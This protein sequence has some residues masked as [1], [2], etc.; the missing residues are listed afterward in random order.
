MKCNLLIVI[1]VVSALLRGHAALYAAEPPQPPAVSPGASG[2]VVAVADAPKTE[3]KASNQNDP[4]I[5]SAKKVVEQY[6]EAILKKD[7]EQ[8]LKLVQT[9]N[10]KILLKNADTAAAQ[11]RVYKVGRGEIENNENEAL[12]FLIRSD[13]DDKKEP[14][15]VEMAGKLSR[16]GL[17]EIPLVL[18]K[19]ADGWK[20]DDVKTAKAIQ[21]RAIASAVMDSMQSGRSQEMYYMKE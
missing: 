9:D 17:N 11:M 19:T 5:V 14:E 10:P 7:R 15:L 16:L 21:R 3:P 20:I 4:R 2:S 8:F 13:M 12:I 18:I 1:C 6:R